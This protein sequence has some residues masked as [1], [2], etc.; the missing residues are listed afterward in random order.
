MFFSEREKQ[1]IKLLCSKSQGVALAD[2][3][4][5]LKV[6]RRT[7]YREIANL[8]KSLDSLGMKLKKSRH[9]GYYLVA[10]ESEKHALWQQITQQNFVNFSKQER[11]DAIAL[12]L[13]TKE[14]RDS[15]ESLAIDF[16][17]STRTIQNDLNSIKTIFDY[18]QVELKNLNEIKVQIVG[19][20][21]KIRQLIV[22]L[23]DRN[24]KA[25]ELFHFLRELTSEKETSN[26]NHFF[27]SVFPQV[28]YEQVSALVDSN[29][30]HENIVQL[31]DNQL[32]KTLLNLLVNVYRMRLSHSIHMNSLEKGL[33]AHYLR[34]AY[35][36][37]TIIFSD[38]VNTSISMGER[39]YFAHQLEGMNFNRSQ[40]IFSNDFDATLTYQ[41]TELIRQV[42]HLTGYNFREDRVLSID[43][44]A[45]MEAAVNRSDHLTLNEPDVLSKM[46]A[47]YPYILES[48][49]KSIKTVFPDL[50]FN[51]EEIAYIVL[52][53]A[54]AIE[55]QPLT[56]SVK[57]AI[58][59]SGGIG[60]SR[61]L[62]S[63]FK[64][65]IPEVHSVTIYKTS[66]INELNSEDY[67]LILATEYLPNVG[68]DYQMIS[69]LLLDNEAIKI[70]E[71]IKTLSH[72]SPTEENKGYPAK[73]ESNRF[74]EM[75][76][77]V[78]AGN[79]LLEQFQVRNE[80]AEASLSGT[81][82]NIIAKL[83]ETI[84]INPANITQEIV[85]RYQE[86]PIG[87]PNSNIALFH[88]SSSHVKAAYFA[89]IDLDKQF[90]IM[91]MDQKY[92]QLQRILL[93]LAPIDISNEEERLLGS[94]SSS[95]I[96]SDL[97]TEIYK[98]GNEQLISQLL[99]HL[100]VQATLTK[101]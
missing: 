72:N 34:L 95:I 1:I 55:R 33:S 66:Q 77:L 58:V 92:I 83:D 68:F 84:I 8:E 57:V 100:F 69:P 48:V 42:S 19:N 96:D 74:K 23:L 11:Q 39:V 4:Q 82:Y 73:D 35:K 52:H 37:Y 40:D 67:H 49:K 31:P 50:V 3:E 17:V 32:K 94:I 91:G 60:S 7:V 20:E 70:R 43:L 98:Y 53:F 63:R 2:L 87:I 26:Y 24:I 65:K 76:H 88:I 47:R 22:Y 38:T 51:S 80:Q 44:L 90:E 30:Y 16:Q 46:T 81:L 85:K 78:N 59:S 71:E 75:Y 21:I 86:A 45:H 5:V 64:N 97:N 36:I 28:I 12:V 29:L 27:L 93:M 10:T 54:S 56:K 41:V 61:V 15:I 89:V 13:L 25:F 14:Q 9:Q 6:S 62:E 79:Q 18:Y 101:E 99:S